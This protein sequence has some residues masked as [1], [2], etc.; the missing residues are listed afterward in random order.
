MTNAAL[1]RR[2]FLRVGTSATLMLAGGSMLA[3]LTGCSSPS[4]PATD[5]RSLRQGDVELLRP[6]VPTILGS[7]VKNADDIERSLQLL[8]ELL[9]ASSDV[10][11]GGLF[12]LY[13]LLQLGAARWWLSGFW[14]APAELSETDKVAALQAWSTKDSGFARIAFRG[15]TQPIL[16]SWF[17]DT[18]NSLAT[19]YPGPPQKVVS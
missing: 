11:R 8:D 16:L 19:G 7:S 17:A 3:G 15:L 9:F 12:Q 18:K 6:L 2:D 14:S 13:D 4:V 10:V 1:S 5:F